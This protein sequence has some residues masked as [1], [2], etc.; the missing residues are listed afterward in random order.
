[1]DAKTLEA[2]KASIA[3]WERNA[4]VTYL[5]DAQVYGDT[6]PLC[7]LFSKEESSDCHGCPVATKTG[8]PQCKGSP[9]V[10]AID[11]KF[12]YGLKAFRAAARKEAEFLK[13]LLPAEEA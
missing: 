9:W 7:A 12:D 6:C 5:Y 1:M 3:K 2:L 10:D 4:E 11:A 13:S 8:K